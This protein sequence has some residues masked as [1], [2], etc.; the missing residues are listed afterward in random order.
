MDRDIVNIIHYLY[1]HGPMDWSDLSMV[2]WCDED[3]KPDIRKYLD[4]QELR[5]ALPDQLIAFLKAVEIQMSTLP[6]P[7]FAFGY[8]LKKPVRSAGELRPC[9]AVMPYSKPWSTSVKQTIKKAAESAGYSCEITGDLPTPGEIVGQIWQGLRDADAVIVDITDDNPNVYYEL[10]LAHALGK[11]VIIIGQ[12]VGDLPFDIRTV[13]RLT[14]DETD[15][16]DL[17]QK[18]TSALIA[19][20][21]RYPHEGPEPRF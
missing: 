15:L 16:P 9:Y 14:Y 7:D 1:R 20:S 17:K 11:E 12:N 8:P 4:P 21:A 10:G 3:S 18:L 13:R 5:M 19:V 2:A 6:K